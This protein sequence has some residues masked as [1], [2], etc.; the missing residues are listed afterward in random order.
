M[1]LSFYPNF[2]NIGNVLLCPF[3]INK[4]KDFNLWEAYLTNQHFIDEHTKSPPVYS[5]CIGRFCQDFW[6][7]KLWSATECT[8]S[9][10]KSHSW[11]KAIINVKTLQTTPFHICFFLKLIYVWCLE[12]PELLISDANY[13]QHQIQSNLPF[14]FCLL[15]SSPSRIKN[16]IG[17]TI[18]QSR[19]GFQT[20]ENPLK[21]LSSL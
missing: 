1:S 5:S 10:T 6:S 4:E 14:V 9:V 16:T 2:Q 18:F 3:S 19:S 13:H 7:K 11:N 20:L 12:I 17:L 15:L 8:C 21:L